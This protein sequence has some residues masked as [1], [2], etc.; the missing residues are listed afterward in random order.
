MYLL[1]DSWYRFAFRPVETLSPVILKSMIKPTW[2]YVSS[3]S[4]ATS[5]I[6]SENDK[7]S[8]RPHNVPALS[9]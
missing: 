4:L 8:T 9:T 7:N 5:G 1:G 2:K 3:E 6:Y